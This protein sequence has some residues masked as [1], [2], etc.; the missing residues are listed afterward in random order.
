MASAEELAALIENTVRAVLAG[1]QGQCS[2]AGTAHSPGNKRILDAKGRSRVETFNG[3]EGQW[4]EW[5]FQFRVAIK[6]MDS[7]VA[8]IMTKEEGKETN[9]TI[10]DL[11]LEYGNLDV[12]KVAGELYDLLCLRVRGI[13]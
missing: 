1:L 13:L 4:R 8:E 7:W 6:A 10:E 3:K 2:T 12:S 5:A 11:E 9:S